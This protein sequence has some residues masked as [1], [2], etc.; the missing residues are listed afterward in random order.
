MIM[1]LNQK[2]ITY[3]RKKS[4]TWRLKNTQITKGSKEKT[5]REIRKYSEMKSNE[6]TIY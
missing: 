2:S 1:V 6:N 5:N 4:D 3:S